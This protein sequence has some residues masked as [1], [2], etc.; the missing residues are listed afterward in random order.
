LL[1]ICS[2]EEARVFLGLRKKKAKE[3]LADEGTIVP[4]GR[5]IAHD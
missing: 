2:G 5:F 3:A 4:M 1:A